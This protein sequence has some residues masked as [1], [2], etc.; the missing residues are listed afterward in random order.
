[1]EPDDYSSDDQE[2]YQDEESSSQDYYSND[3]ETHFMS[4]DDPE[5]DQLIEDLN[6]AYGD[7]GRGKERRRQDHRN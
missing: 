1:M 5:I 2:S 6:E 7:Q 4:Y 3:E